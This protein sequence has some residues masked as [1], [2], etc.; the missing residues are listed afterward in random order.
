MLPG[1]WII[2][3]AGDPLEAFGDA[4]AQL[5][6]LI[7][8][9]TS[10]EPEEYAD[11]AVFVTGRTRSHL[12]IVDPF[13]GWKPSIIQLSGY[14]G[15]WHHATEDQYKVTI[16]LSKE[17]CHREMLHMFDTHIDKFKFKPMRKS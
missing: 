7:G 13:D 1:D 5:R 8:M 9:I 15:H 2:R 12:T 6:F 17:R 10:K 14:S 4:D 16:A 11:H 3:E